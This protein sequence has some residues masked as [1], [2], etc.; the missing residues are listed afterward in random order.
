MSLMSESVVGAVDCVE[1]HRSSTGPS[2][3]VRSPS[4]WRLASGH[5]WS[6][7]KG[8]WTATI[9]TLKF[10]R[11]TTPC[12]ALGANSTRSIRQWWRCHSTHFA[13]CR[14]PVRYWLFAFRSFVAGPRFISQ[15]TW[16]L[17]RAAALLLSDYP[18]PFAGG[19]FG[20][21][22]WT[23]HIKCAVGSSVP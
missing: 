23:L 7:S 1:Q 12:C 11:P 21:D 9:K 4:G 8:T 22:F 14:A 6:D 5:P 13:S 18:I 2:L 20:D 10:W 19:M 3:I 16:R 17:V 15:T